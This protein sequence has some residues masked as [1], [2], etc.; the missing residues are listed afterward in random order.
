MP[1]F[2]AWQPIVLAII[3]LATAMIPLFKKIQEAN[4]N[5]KSAIAA[6]SSLDNKVTDLKTTADTH[7]NQLSDIQASI[8]GDAA[9]YQREIES[10]KQELFEQNKPPKG[11]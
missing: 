10:L 7:T 3:G 11:V 9:A 6:A 5:A 8:G 4:Q 2:Q 1:D